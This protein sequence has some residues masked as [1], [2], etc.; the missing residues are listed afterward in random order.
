MDTTRTLCPTLRHTTSINGSN[1]P[2]CDALFVVA[3][4][5]KFQVC[6]CICPPMAKGAGKAEGPQPRL[7]LTVLG[8]DV[9]GRPNIA[10]A[11]PTRNTTPREDFSKTRKSTSHVRARPLSD[12]LL[13]RNPLGLDCAT[14]CKENC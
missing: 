4:L 3:C 1:S 9:F 11:M 12:W 2:Q 5:S 6:A 8:Q 13:L 10:L 14:F 7:I